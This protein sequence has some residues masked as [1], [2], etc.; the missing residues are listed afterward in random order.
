MLFSAHG[1]T[2]RVLPFLPQLLGR[3]SGIVGS[4]HGRWLSSVG[5]A[6]LYHGHRFVNVEHRS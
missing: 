2:A 6:H 5:G 3:H 1:L 4:P